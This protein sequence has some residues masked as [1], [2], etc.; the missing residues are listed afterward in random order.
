MLVRLDELFM[1]VL[2]ALNVCAQLFSSS[3]LLH[4]TGDIPI[5]YRPFHISLVYPYGIFNV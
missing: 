1:V 3:T 4:E 2:H 5:H